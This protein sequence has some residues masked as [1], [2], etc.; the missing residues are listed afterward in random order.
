MLTKLQFEHKYQNLLL[1]KYI[2]EIN[3]LTYIMKNG[4]SVKM[5]NVLE[6][7]LSINMLVKKIF[8]ALLIN[9]FDKQQKNVNNILNI[10][11]ILT[12]IRIRK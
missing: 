7:I 9:K 12:I 2:D 1:I 6:I 11:R 3:A 8:N 4:M 10:L 5:K